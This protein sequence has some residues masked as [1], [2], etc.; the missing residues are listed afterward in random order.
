[1]KSQ[2]LALV[3]AG[4]PAVTQ[5]QPAHLLTSLATSGP[6]KAQGKEA[7]GFDQDATAHHP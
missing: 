2:Q 1:M 3:I 7:M 5:N 6:V 4:E